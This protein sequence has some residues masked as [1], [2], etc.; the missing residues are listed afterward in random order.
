[1]AGS[2]GDK[3]AWF[4]AGMGIGGVCALLLAPQSGRETREE[5]ARRAQEG[6][7]YLNKKVDEGRQLI[8]ESGRRVSSEVT[9][10]VERGRDQVGELVEMGK[11]AVHE[12]KEQLTA[13]YDAGKQ[14]YRSEKGKAD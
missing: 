8:E 14:A 6:R 5:I 9:S 10:A 11:Q 12:Q 1:M 2:A 13:A 4:I 3:V 7:N